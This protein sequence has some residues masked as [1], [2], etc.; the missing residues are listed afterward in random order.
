[1]F[2]TNWRRLAALAFVSVS[3]SF[4]GVTSAS[5]VVPEIVV[6]PRTAKAAPQDDLATALVQLTFADIWNAP[7]TVVTWRYAPW[8]AN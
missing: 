6:D 1:M 3:L 4:V 2:S 8:H 5:A 7:R